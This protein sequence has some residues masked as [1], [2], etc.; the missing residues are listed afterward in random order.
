MI[1]LTRIL[2]FKIASM[3]IAPVLAFVLHNL[4]RP[5][6]DIQE[7]CTL[8]LY[9]FDNDMAV[10]SFNSM[11]CSPAQFGTKLRPLRATFAAD[12][13]LI[14]S[15]QTVNADGVQHG[16]GKLT[17]EIETKPICLASAAD[18]KTALGDDFGCT[19]I[20]SF[21]EKKDNTIVILRRGTICLAPARQNKDLCCTFAH[22]L[23]LQ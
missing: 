16:T 14:T 17:S 6:V 2:N 5:T 21:R 4:A 3:L 7:L 23:S 12:V 20:R 13:Q 19:F 11:A 9:N 15:I 8:R 22:T 1:R 18:T 10:S